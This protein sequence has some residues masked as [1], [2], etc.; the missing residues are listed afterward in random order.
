MYANAKQHL[1]NKVKNTMY[2]VD[3]TPTEINEI[4]NT[5]KNKTTSDT[6]I[7]A[8]K[9][10]NKAFSFSTVICNIVNTSFHEGIVPV[11]L[12]LAKV[13][14]IHK[15][16]KRTDVTNYRSISLLSAFSKIYER[17]MHTRVENFVNSSNILHED[18]YGFRKKRSCEHAL[19]AAQQKI[20]DSLDKKQIALLLLIDFSMAFD[21]VDHQILLKS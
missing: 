5:F 14:P 15:S 9:A 19:V 2:I 7:I 13:V 18:Q 3:T 4:I 16:G 6:A 20:L 21:M 12:K 17:A 11:Q 10:A 8:L 1:S